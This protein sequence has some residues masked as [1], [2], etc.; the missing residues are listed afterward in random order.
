[1]PGQVAAQRRSARRAARRRRATSACRRSRCFRRSTTALKDPRGTRE[2]ERGRPAAARG[3][4]RSSARA[5]SA[6]D[7][8]R[9][10]RSVQLGRSRRRGHRR[11]HRQRR[12]RADPG[13]HGRRA[14]ARRRR[15]RGAERHDGR[16]GR[17]D[18]RG[19]RRSRF[20]ERRHLQLL[21]E[22]RL[23]VLRP[24][25]RGARFGAARSGD[26][27]TYQ[28]DPAN[29]REALREVRLDEAEGADWLM[30]KPGL[31]YLDVH[32]LRAREDAL[33]GRDVSRERRV[34]DAQGRRAKRLARLRPVPAREP[35]CRCAAPAPTSS[36]RTARSRRRS[37]SAAENWAEFVR[38]FPGAPARELAYSRAP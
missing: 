9:R 26:K 37:S 38:V 13:G 30:V 5:G 18:P 31:P 1:M 36:S 3:A 25:P 34:R 8:G 29:V 14:G 24:V 21:G 6:G 16:P 20:P 4:R 12:D 33:A 19:A 15:H 28:M 35:A 17:R 7:H 22:V 11:P 2:H 23:R 32:P 10:A 27:K